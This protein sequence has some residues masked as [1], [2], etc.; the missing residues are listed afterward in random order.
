MGLFD[1]NFDS[2]GSLVKDVRE[3]VT[4]EAIKDPN[5]KAEIEAKMVEL[6][7]QLKMGQLAINK[8]EAKNKNWFISGARPFILWICGFAVAY[9]FIIAPF[10]HSIFSAF[11]IDFPLPNIDMG[12]LFQLMTAML[13]MS[14]LRTYEKLKGVQSKH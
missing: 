11:K 7:N 8:E 13:G 2:I 1:I 9:S 6:E 12:V 14:G 4:G 10:L 5:K 3:A